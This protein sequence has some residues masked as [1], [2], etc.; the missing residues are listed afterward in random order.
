MN[1]RR[2]ICKILQLVM[3]ERSQASKKEKTLVPQ[4]QLLAPPILRIRR[5]EV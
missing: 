2:K 3:L 1:G 5:D 4:K